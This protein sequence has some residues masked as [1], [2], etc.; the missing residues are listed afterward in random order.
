[1]PTLFYAQAKGLDRQDMRIEAGLA[2]GWHGALP[3]H[4]SP[5]LVRGRVDEMLDGEAGARMRAALAQ[6][7]PANGALRAAVELLLTCASLDGSALDAGALLEVACW[8]RDQRPV[9]TATFVDDARSYLAWRHLAASAPERAGERESAVA[10]WWKNTTSEAW[11]LSAAAELRALRE[12][13]GA[14][15]ETWRALQQAFASHPSRSGHREKLDELLDALRTLGPAAIELA[16]SQPG[17]ALR[18]S[19]RDLVREREAE[20]AH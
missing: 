15:D 4:P 16:R 6:R 17:R 1:V 2:R 14:D 10:R 7:D 5:E 12:S 13:S 11:P 9:S 20:P 8:R 19:I 18:D 3:E